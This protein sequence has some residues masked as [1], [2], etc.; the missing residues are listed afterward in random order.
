[1][2]RCPLDRPIEFA[3]NPIPSKSSSD[4]EIK[5][6]SI[7]DSG[8]GNQLFRWDWCNGHALAGVPKHQDLIVRNSNLDGLGPRR[9]RVD[10]DRH[11][12]ETIYVFKD[13]VVRAAS[14]IGGRDLRFCVSASKSR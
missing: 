14:C 8:P 6:G 2:V 5:K 11:R 3:L 9:S 7:I 12:A 13:E 10:R 4:V 1:M